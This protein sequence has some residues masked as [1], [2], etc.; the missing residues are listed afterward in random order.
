MEK[1]IYLHWRIYT[2]DFG[3]SSRLC[4]EGQIDH[5]PTFVKVEYHYADKALIHEQE[6]GYL[7]DAVQEHFMHVIGTEWPQIL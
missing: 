2:D 4:H 3:I 1:F 7:F 6:T 5:H